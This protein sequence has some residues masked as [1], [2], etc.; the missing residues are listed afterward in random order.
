M[1]NTSGE[2]LIPVGSEIVGE[3]RPNG[4]GT[5]FVAEAL[6][7]PGG[8]RFALNA[9]SQTVTTVETISRGASL[10]ET[11][12]GAAIGSGAAAAIAGLT[13]DQRVET[14]EVLAGT[15]TGATIARLLGRDQIEVITVNPSQDLS[16][17]MNTALTLP[18][19]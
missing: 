1:T 15:A 11:L 3:L 12:L 19:Q 7:L 8:D 17:V 16:L 10:G 14:L 2:I 5:Q 6:V 18:T 4:E 13:G 9:T